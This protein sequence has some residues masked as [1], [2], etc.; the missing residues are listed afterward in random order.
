VED[1]K[2]A[3]KLVKSLDMAIKYERLAQQRYSREATYSYEYD[4]K[5]LFKSLVSEELKHERLL[6]GKKAE[7]L[8]DIARLS[9]KKI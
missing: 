6:A 5:V 7:V 8:K 3:K 1:L 9:K 2:L 4:V